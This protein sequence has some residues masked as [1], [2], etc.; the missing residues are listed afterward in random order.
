M[1]I[2]LPRDKP[3]N[4]TI[5]EL[6]KWLI[7]YSQEIFPS[8]IINFG[9]SVRRV[10]ALRECLKIAFKLQSGELETLIFA[11]MRSL[12]INKSK[13]SSDYIDTLI[14]FEVIRK[15]SPNWDYIG[16]KPE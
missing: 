13:A 15:R 7:V 11:I 2:M 4:L 12:G 6:E 9:G 10:Q 5:P 14:D 8:P 16:K 3:E 1:A